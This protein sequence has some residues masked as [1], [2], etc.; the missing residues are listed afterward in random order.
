MAVALSTLGFKVIQGLDLDKAALDRTVREFSTALQGAEVGLFFYAGHGLQVSGQNY[1][2]PTDAQL[3]SLA[4]LEVETMRFESVQRIMESEDRTNILFFDACRDNPLARNLAEA[5]GT[6][7]VAIGR[8][9]AP[10]QSGQGTLISFSTQ[11]GSVALDGRGRNSPFT[12][13]LVRRLLSSN[14]EIMA[15]LVDVRIDV[16]RETN[17]QQVP[18]D[19]T[20]LTA[21]FYFKTV[22]EVARPAPAPQIVPGT[23][24][25]APSPQTAKP[26]LSIAGNWSGQLTQVGSQWPYKFELVIGPRGAQTTYPDLDCTGTL[27]RVGASESYVF[28]VE[29]IT[30]GQA[31][32]GGRCPDGTIT[33]TRVGSHLLLF[34]FGCIDFGSTCVAFGTLSQ[35]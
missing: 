9:L 29:N 31:L 33:A 10:V 17:R 18:W 4:A 28:F 30:R 6:R 21:R 27:T 1:I 24:L 34:W 13:A 8:G 15:L 5:M 26:S 11:P 3:K 7:S 23:V 2:I 35:K 32:K 19:H 12:G 14:E 20:A 25:P 16:M 22:P